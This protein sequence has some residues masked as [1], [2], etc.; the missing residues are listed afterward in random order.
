MLGVSAVT[1]GISKTGVPGIT[2][3]GTVFVPMVMSAK[4][5]TGY[6]LPFLLFA[7]IIAVT[8]WRRA[9]V[10]RH[11]IAL[12]PAMFVGIIAGFFLMDSIEDAV[13]GKVLGGIVLGLLGADAVFRHFHIQI[14]QNS[15]LFTWGMGFLAGVMTMLANA[16]GPAMMLYLLTMNISKEEFVGTSAWIYLAINIFKIPFSV[17][18]GLITLDSL[19]V[20]L[21]LL[22]CI[23]LGSFL[24]VW[25]I[26]RISGPLFEK[27]MR[28]MVFLGGIKLFF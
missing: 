14:P 2:M 20:N 3:L 28:G 6:I 17:Q 16:A 12:L 26:R 1:A 10:V 25:M 15:R 9:A 11:I 8:Y 4:E 13:Y 22:P 27:L 21:L 18:L 24:G 23:I 5:S 7:D 19:S